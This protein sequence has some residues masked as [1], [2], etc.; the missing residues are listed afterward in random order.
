MGVFLAESSRTFITTLSGL[1]FE[2]LPFLL[3][4]TALSSAI[5]VFV[6]ASAFRKILPR[7]RFAAIIVAAAVG[8][9]IPVCECAIVP[10]ARRLRDKGVPESAAL[11]FMLA[12]PIVNPMT[13]VSTI[14]AFNGTG[15]PVWALRIG[16]GLAVA[17]AVSVLHEIA[18]PSSRETP[19]GPRFVR[20]ADGMIARAP[21]IPRA[22]FS[23]RA[24]LN[25]GEASPDAARQAARPRIGRFLVHAG[26][27]FIDTSRFLILGILLASL[28]RALIPLSAVSRALSSP[29][30]AV[31]AGMAIAFALS[32]CSSA[33]AFVA[34]TLFVPQSYGAAIAFMIFGPMLDVKTAS[35]LSRFLKRGELARLAAALVAACLAA[36]IALSFLWRAWA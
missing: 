2:T 26:D 33:D 8:A 5:H 13:L 28:A 21:L 32:L 20:T 23:A 27:E 19:S 18:R 24:A 34:R 35:L 11:A 30:L 16:A 17:L 14:V 22:P 4:G 36:T 3:I 12:A 25:A 15:H 29:F 1:A 7:N 6:P 10:L 31:P 9:V